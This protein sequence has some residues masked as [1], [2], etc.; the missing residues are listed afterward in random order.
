MSNHHCLLHISN[1]NGAKQIV[2]RG[3]LQQP[4]LAVHDLLSVI[5]LCKHISSAQILRAK[6]VNVTTKRL[7]TGSAHHTRNITL[8]AKSANAI[9][10]THDPKQTIEK[11]SHAELHHHQKALL[12]TTCNSYQNQ[13]CPR[14]YPYPA[15]PPYAL[16]STPLPSAASPA[17]L[18]AA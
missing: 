17:L 16:P 13:N 6:T 18:V 4:A 5:N 9:A 7:S 10:T 8:Q 12:I 2:S 1:R 15:L 11:L 14:T 3:L